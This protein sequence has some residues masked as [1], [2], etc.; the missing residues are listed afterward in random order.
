MSSKNEQAHL[1]KRLDLHTTW[2][3]VDK[4]PDFDTTIPLD[5][6]TTSDAQIGTWMGTV[7]AW[8]SYAYFQLGILELDRAVTSKRFAQ[9]VNAGIVS[10]GAKQ[11]TYDLQVAEVIQGAAQLQNHQSDLADLEGQIAFWSR[12]A[13][14]Y[15]TY[16]N[17]FK[18]ESWRRS[19]ESKL[20][21]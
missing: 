21:N 16:L 6:T 15:E 1:L 11:R 13:K 8:L 2:L 10:S 12:A 17:L 3:P 5:V 20:G 14:A 7:T 9:Q 19:R 4:P 18:E